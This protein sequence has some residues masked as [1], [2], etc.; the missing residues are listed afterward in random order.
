MHGAQRGIG[1][2]CVHVVV[3]AATPRTLL[4][5]SHLGESAAPLSPHGAAAS[6]RRGSSRERSSRRSECRLWPTE[7]RHLPSERRHFQPCIWQVS[8]PSST[9]PNRD[10]SAFKCAHRRCT[11][12]PS[13]SIISAASAAFCS[14]YQPSA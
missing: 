13:S 10:R 11:N 6:R 9:T 7:V 14:V 12:Q 2:G 3:A 5:R 4:I 8:T 1:P